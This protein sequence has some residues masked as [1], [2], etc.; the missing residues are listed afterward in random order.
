MKKDFVKYLLKLILGV[1]LSAL[2]WFGLKAHGE[3]N[4]VKPVVVKEQGYVPFADAPI[5][6]RSEDLNDP[7]A[8]MQKELDRGAVTLEYDSRH[9]YLQSVLRALRIS[10]ASQTLVF[11]KTSFQYPR[12][13]PERP[14]ALYFND[15]V[16]VGQVDNGRLLEFVSFDPLQGAIFYVMDERRA[17]HPRFE[18][19]ELDCIQ[20]HV[21]ATTKNVP[22]VMLRSV[23][24]G[25]SGV[26]APKTPAY[27]TGHES[28]IK[29]RWGGWYVTGRPGKLAQLGN[30]I[31]PAQ[32]EQIP[33]ELSGTID[34]SAYLTGYSDIVAHLVLA[35]QT[36]MH[37]LITQTNYQTRLALAKSGGE[38]SDARRA[39]ERPA[40][41]LVRYL[42]FANEAPL[43]SPIAGTSGFA[44]EFA[45]RG[46]RDPQGRSLRDFDLT[47][48]IFRY[49]C[50]YLI[51]SE[52]FD[53]IPEP[54]KSYV[55]RRLLEVLTNQDQSPD[56]AA[57]S[58][59]DRRAV[60]EILLATKLTLPG[61][62]KH[63]A[64]QILT[65][66]RGNQ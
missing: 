40:E 46:P 22:G 59:E 36:Q 56:F 20:C 51:Y 9:G 42:L 15:D 44:E 17:E 10:P 63:S 64:Q 53:A 47:K 50:S 35:H 38:V 41:Q 6:Y 54:A 62:W 52:S 4:L 25:V 23:Y 24:T 12:I 31:Y 14:R 61:G 48:R 65:A 18:R 43:D 7:I 32:D 27:I 28:P 55:Y 34:T 21:A 13:S 5:N 60:L 3:T 8:K 37:N 45:A 26:Q 33:A 16:Y 58:A 2:F 66:S 11:S 29:E 39:F 57:L 30:S 1:S 49:P 19:S